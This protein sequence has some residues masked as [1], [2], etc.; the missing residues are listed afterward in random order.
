MSLLQ[1]KSLTKNYRVGGFLEPHKVVR[2]LSDVTLDV[3]QSE[4]LAVVG[5]SGCGKSTLAKVL[6]GLEPKSSGEVFFEGQSLESL[7]RS[8]LCRQVQM[9]F[10]DP[11]SS[12]NPRKRIRQII[13]EPLIV[14]SKVKGSEL[15]GIVEETAKR[16]GLRSDYLNRFPHMF[17][18]GQRQRVGIARALVLR[19]KLLICDEPV[20]A[21]DVSVQS[22]VLNLLNDLQSELKLSYVFISHDLGIVRYLA[23]RV[24]VMYL[25]R[26]VELGET[27]QIFSNP[28][29]PYTQLLL[30]ST[31][32]FKGKKRVEEKILATPEFKGIELPSPLNIPSGCAFHTRCPMATERC[33]RERPELREVQGRN[34][35]C[36]NVGLQ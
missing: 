16:V 27:E 36:H 31:P 12:L 2:A 11:Y 9:I 1:V 34:V 24:A 10:Q 4:T 17:S 19:P 20:S 29:H 21:L 25:G 35:A 14:N 30:S 33:S 32:I 22:Q 26:V 13:A 18:G 15:D 28:Q 6:M 23:D 8:E 7:S 5:E 3:A